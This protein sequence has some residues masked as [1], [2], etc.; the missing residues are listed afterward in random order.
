MRRIHYFLFFT[1]F[2][3]YVAI[4][5]VMW[6]FKYDRD[7][8]KKYITFERYGGRFSNQMFQLAAAFQASEVFKRTLIIP[9]EKRVV[10]YTGMFESEQGLPIWD[11][12]DLRRT[13]HFIFES[14]YGQEMSIPKHCI[15]DP[16]ELFKDR[17]RGKN[18]DI[19]SLGGETRLLYCK[20]NTFCGTAAEQRIAF[21]FYHSLKP[22]R[23]I[24]NKIA[25]TTGY[26]IGI[27]SRS[28]LGSGDKKLCFQKSMHTLKKIVPHHSYGM[29]EMIGLTCETRD[30][31]KV[32]KL[33]KLLNLTGSDIV[34]SSDLPTHT[35]IG[36]TRVPKIKLDY[37]YDH[38]FFWSYKPSRETIDNLIQVIYEQGVLSKTKYFIGNMYSTFS[39]TVCIMRGEERKLLSN[40]CDINLHPKTNTVNDR[41]AKG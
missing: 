11:L 36:G 15:I 20:R 35:M 28:F 33:I 23:T 4:A 31:A 39:F 16:I 25:M 17:K 22:H 3:A 27:H 26:D 14:Q 19:I 8:P 32:H 18:C 7:V 10:D 13:F 12:G 41:W 1:A 5:N 34:F 9:Y 37:A 29:R 21:E 24:R 40:I 38:I 30:D 2:V 6:F